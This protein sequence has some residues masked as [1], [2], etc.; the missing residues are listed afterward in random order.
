[1]LEVQSKQVQPNIVV[2]QRAG[3]MTLGRQCAQLERAVDNLVG[4]GRKKLFLI[5]AA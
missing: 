4:E 5:S 1:M 3:R 2:L